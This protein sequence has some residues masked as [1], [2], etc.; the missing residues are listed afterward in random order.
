M[1]AFN[2]GKPPMKKI[3]LAVAAGALLWSLP[4]QAATLQGHLSIFGN[5]ILDAQNQ[6]ITFLSGTSFAPMETGSFTALG[7]NPALVWQNVGHPLHYS[8]LGTGSDLYCGSNCLFVAAVDGGGT[9]LTF[10][11]LTNLVTTDNLLTM[12]GTGLVSLTGFDAAIIPFSLTSQGGINLGFTIDP[13][14]PVPLPGTLPSLATGL[15]ALFALLR[16]RKTV[17]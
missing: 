6:T 12:V 7:A 9:V 17:G 3:L 5:D 2:E 11:V 16:R 14:S 1:G 10:N 8:Q 4:A 13:P 15:L